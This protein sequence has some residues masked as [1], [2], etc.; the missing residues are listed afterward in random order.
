M[1]VLKPSKDVLEHFVSE[2][3]ILTSLHHKNIIS[4]IGFCCDEN[5]LLLVYNLLSRG[6]LEENLHGIYMCIF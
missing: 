6:C 3:E 1:K 2:I 5:Q 4:L